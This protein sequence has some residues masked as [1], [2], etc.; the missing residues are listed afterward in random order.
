MIA[1]VFLVVNSIVSSGWFWFG[2]DPLGILIRL[3]VLS[4]GLLLTRLI[5]LYPIFSRKTNRKWL[6]LIFIHGSY[7]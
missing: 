5:R 4:L 6:L 3:G 1:L 7:L 2:T